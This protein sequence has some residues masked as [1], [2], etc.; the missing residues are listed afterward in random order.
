MST[1]LD[2]NSR[3]SLFADETIRTE[4]RGTIN[5]SMGRVKLGLRVTLLEPQPGRRINMFRCSL[6][7]AAIYGPVDGLHVESI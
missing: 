3:Y 6:R 1:S 7:L 2:P 4:A 5:L